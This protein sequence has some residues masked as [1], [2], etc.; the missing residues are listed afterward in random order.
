MRRARGAVSRVPRRTALVAGIS[1]SLAVALVIFLAARGHPAEGPP[2]Q[3]IPLQYD[4]AAD[5]QAW[6][7]HGSASPS[8]APTLQPQATRPFYVVLSPESHGNRYLVKLLVAAGCAGHGSHAQP[9]D[10]PAELDAHWPN[11][12]TVTPAGAAP[13]AAMH[14]SMPHAGV[15]INVTQLDADIRAAGW[16]PRFLTLLRAEDAAAASQVAAGHARTELI[17]VDRILQAQRAILDELR[18]R[19]FR[20]VLYEQL[21][22]E[23]YRRWL[24]SQQLHM[25]L[26]STAPAFREG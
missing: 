22:H 23:H 7:P 5:E 21:A 24:F 15:W 25:W 2:R 12:V 13:C 14:R 16:E 26:P 10:V 4:S 8:R 3:P 1:T 11:R 17:A 20:F 6:Q 18:G 19:W 9:F